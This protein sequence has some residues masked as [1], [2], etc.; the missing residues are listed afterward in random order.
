MFAWIN[1]AILVFASILFLYFYMRSASPAGREKIIGPRAYQLCSYDRLIAAGLEGIVTANYI[2]YFFYPLDTPLPV[3]FPWA[4]WIS[5]VIALLIGIP[6]TAL[7]LNG[8]RHAGE[9]TMRPRKEHTMYGGIY[10]RM[11]HP[12]A[13]GEVFLFWV[14]A[15][16]L[17]S[18]F[19][20]LFSF[21][22]FPIFVIIC[23]AEEQDL[24]LRYGE[25]YAE[26]C[27]R[28]GAF[29]PRKRN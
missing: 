21:I 24:L 27:R 9:E 22:Y 19:L 3:K 4:W 17:N 8:V 29:W 15:L 26:Y 28:T 11:R 1:F 20:A 12:Q 18:P 5:L 10:T 7:M 13:V 2:L 23:Y 16:L 6:A 14:I 25:S